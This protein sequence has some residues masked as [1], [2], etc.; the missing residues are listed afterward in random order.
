MRYVVG[1]SHDE[2]VDRFAI[3]IHPSPLNASL[4]IIHIGLFKVELQAD[5]F[6]R[7]SFSR[8]TQVLVHGD[9]NTHVGALEYLI[10]YDPMLFF[11]HKPLSSM[12]PNYHES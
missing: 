1:G 8:R 10:E 7:F 11:M 4:I 2:P 12:T 3:L 6:N 5:A 9:H